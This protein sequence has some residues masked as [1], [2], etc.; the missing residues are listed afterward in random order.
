MKHVGT[1]GQPQSRIRFESP[2]DKAE[3]RAVESVLVANGVGGWTW[4][5]EGG[6]VTLMA[7]C[8]P[9]W[10]GEA[11]AHRQSIRNALEAISANGLKTSMV[12]YLVDVTVM[13]PDT[14]DDFIP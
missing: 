9:Q 6:K 8:I 10:G 11:N 1:G 4:G 5:R 12:E 7:T 14:Y 2:L 3:M 13:E